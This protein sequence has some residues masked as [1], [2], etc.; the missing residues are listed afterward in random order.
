VDAISDDGAQAL[1]LIAFIGSVFSPYYA[2]AKHPAA[3]ENHCAM[4]I[5]LY[6]PRGGHWAMTERGS[7]ALRRNADVLEIGPSCL[8]WENGVLTA[9]ISEITFPK[10]RR[11]RGKFTLTPAAIQPETFAL[12][13]GGRHF[14]RPIAPCARID[15]EFEKPGICWSGEAYFDSNWGAA[16]LSQ[17]FVTWE[18]SRAATTD[19]ATVIYDVKRR[20]GTA[21][22]LALNIG[23]DGKAERFDAPAAQSLPG[24]AWGIARSARADAGYKPRVVKTLESAPFYARSV[25]ETQMGGRAMMAM[26]ESLSL[27]RFGTNWVKWMLPFRM[28]RRW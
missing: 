22:G 11:L 17:D 16:P 23:R 18:W 1:T 7:G 15:V 6:Q 12:D 14:W 13:S 8:W 19:G 24:T 21:L 28:P 25:V 5:V 10:L 2:W 4:N 9:D 20:D 3:P 26:H 27:D